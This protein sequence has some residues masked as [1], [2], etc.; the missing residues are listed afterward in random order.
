MAHVGTLDFYRV[1]Q[2]DDSWYNG[3]HHLSQ[4]THLELVFENFI[5]TSSLLSVLDYLC[6]RKF[7]PFP[8]F[9]LGSLFFHHTS[10]AYNIAA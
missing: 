6:D 3:V 4:A 5:F 8:R 9:S 7:Y 2:L 10:S 1:K